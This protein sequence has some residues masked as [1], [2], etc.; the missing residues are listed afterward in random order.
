MLPEAENLHIGASY[1]WTL[2]LHFR[3]A[4]GCNY[5]MNKL[6]A[7]ILLA[8]L[9]LTGCQTTDTSSDT[10]YDD[11]SEKIERRKAESEAAPATG[12]NIRIVVSMLTTSAADYFAIDSL[13]Q[14]VDKNIAITKRPEVFAGSG[15]SIGVAGKGF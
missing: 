15:L 11:V 14:Y 13:F 8:F 12:D 3:S 7:S 4:A 5:L 10:H 6:S 1:F 2:P 9:M